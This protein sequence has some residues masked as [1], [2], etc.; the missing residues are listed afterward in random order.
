MFAAES[1][2]GEAE[3]TPVRGLVPAPKVAGGERK[4]SPSAARRIVQVAADAV[5]GDGRVGRIQG[6]DV[7]PAMAS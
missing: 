4:I 1:I 5:L 2:G 6:H 3:A 7:G